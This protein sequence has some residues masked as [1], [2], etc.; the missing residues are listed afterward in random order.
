VCQG[1]RDGMDEMDLWVEYDQCHQDEHAVGFHARERRC[2]G[3][4]KKTRENSPA[5]QWGD[6]QQIEQHQEHVNQDGV[7]RHHSDRQKEQLMPR[8]WR[9]RLFRFGPVVPNRGIDRQEEREEKGA[10]DGQRK[11]HGRPCRRDECHVATG[12]VH[13][14]R[15]DRDRLGP[16]EKESSRHNQAEQRQD[17]GSEGIDV[18]QWIHGEPTLEFGGWIAA[19]IGDPTV[20]VFV[21][22]HGKKE[23]ERHVGYRVE[24]LR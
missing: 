19:P 16:P 1:A 2:R 24:N 18:R 11:V 10:A 5:I 7:D 14:A 23:R 17:D 20:G 8:I 13:K 4:G 12:L 22:Y 21:Q 3:G 9:H 6:R 15:V